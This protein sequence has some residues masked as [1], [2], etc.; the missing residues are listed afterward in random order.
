MGSSSSRPEDDPTL[1]AINEMTLARLKREEQ[2]LA[3]KEQNQ[4]SM[5]DTGR[6]GM[7]SLLSRGYVGFLG[8]GRGMAKKKKFAE[9]EKTVT[10]HSKTQ[11]RSQRIAQKKQ[12]NKPSIAKRPALVPTAAPDGVTFIQ[13]MK[14]GMPNFVDHS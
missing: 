10:P 13:G 11:A 2:D 6:L 1:D 8:G 14:P 4:Q 7:S 12:R 9:D 3:E 5:L